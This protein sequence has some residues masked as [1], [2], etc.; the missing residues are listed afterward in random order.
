M[1]IFNIKFI[2]TKIRKKCW[3]S[4]HAWDV[5]EHGEQCQHYTIVINYLLVYEKNYYLQV[6]LKKCLYR[7]VDSEKM[8]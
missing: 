5:P 8:S 6:Y 1:S 3:L 2:K 7:I 4:F